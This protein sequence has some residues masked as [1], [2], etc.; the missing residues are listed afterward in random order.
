M[1][2]SGLNFWVCAL[3]TSCHGLVN[4]PMCIRRQW[5]GPGGGGAAGTPVPD[6]C[7]PEYP[8]GG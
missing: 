1:R 2:P 6:I 8:G 5:L 7:A 3:M 4:L